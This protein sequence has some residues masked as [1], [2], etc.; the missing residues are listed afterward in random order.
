[1]IVWSRILF[2]S[3]YHE[4]LMMSFTSLIREV[5]ARNLWRSWYTMREDLI[6]AVWMMCVSLNSR[7]PL[8]TKTCFLHFISCLYWLPHLFVLLGD[9]LFLNYFKTKFHIFFNTFM[10]FVDVFQHPAIFV[11][12]FHI[13]KVLKT[14]QM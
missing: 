12:S 5:F 13:I 8:K 14:S 10:L 2:N 11:S 3:R 9:F 4:A 7:T 6:G 1:M